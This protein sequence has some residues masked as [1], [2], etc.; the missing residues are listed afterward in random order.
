VFAIVVTN[1]ERAALLTAEDVAALPQPDLLR[2]FSETDDRDER[3]R[4]LDALNLATVSAPVL[5]ELLETAPTYAPEIV[6]RMDW[7]RRTQEELTALADDTPNGARGEVITA[8]VTRSPHL[9]DWSASSI[10]NLLSTAYADGFG[11]AEFAELLL[12][13]WGVTP[14]EATDHFDNVEAENREWVALLIATSP[15]HFA[16]LV[17]EMRSFPDRIHLVERMLAQVPGGTAKDDV[18]DLHP[19][20]VARCFAWME[21]RARHGNRKIRAR[22]SGTPIVVDP[23]LRLLW[24]HLAPQHV[25][26]VRTALIAVDGVEA[27]VLA[28]QTARPSSARRKR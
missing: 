22:T 7:A 4:I 21:A 25:D 13:R 9:R 16:H 28:P 17:S 3:L 20:H 2:R 18:L 19:H 23:D 26:A 14:G 12:A 10:V 27:A 1:A 6:S 8:I 5:H 24:P 15:P 11:D